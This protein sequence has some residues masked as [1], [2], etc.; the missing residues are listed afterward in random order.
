MFQGIL[1]MSVRSQTQDTDPTTLTISIEGTFSFQKRDEFRE[2]Y[3]NADKEIKNFV[4]DLSNA[5]YID[6]SGL[7]MLLIL[8]DH[9]DTIRGTVVIARPNS[10]VKEL[11]DL[12]N[13]TQIFEI[14]T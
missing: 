6:S 9:A 13:F 5:T 12:S 14:Q 7:G 3:I 2:S 1:K 8:K 4:I 11:L 10:A